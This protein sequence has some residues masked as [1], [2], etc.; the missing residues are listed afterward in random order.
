MLIYVDVCYFMLS[1]IDSGSTFGRFFVDWHEISQI[2]MDF[3][4]P[5]AEKQSLWT[6]LGQAFFHLAFLEEPSF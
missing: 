2:L 4:T 5:D 1:F 6:R 3:V